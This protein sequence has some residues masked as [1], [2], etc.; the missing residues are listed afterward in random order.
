VKAA[1]FQA[2]GR[3][4]VTDVPTPEPGP[5]QVRIR[6]RRCGVCG[7]DVHIHHGDFIATYPLVGGHELAG[8]IDAVGE[9]VVALRPGD[10]VAPDP[11]I[12]CG[13]CHFCRIGRRNHC[14]AFGALGVTVDGGFAEYTVAPQEI[15]YPIGDLPY[16]AGACAEPLA[17]VL[18][19]VRRAAPQAGSSALIFG[20]GPI[21]LL[22]L[23]ALLRSGATSA[24]SV[25]PDPRRRELALELGA[26]AAVEP[27]TDL[28]G[29]APHGFDLV[30]DATGI[31]EVA[32]DLTRHAT[33]G[34]TVMYFGVCPPDSRISLSPFDVYKRDLTIV[35]S[36]SLATE[37]SAALD[38]LGCPGA[39]RTEPL[40]SDVISLD[41][42]PAL[43][44]DG[45]PP[46]SLKIQVEP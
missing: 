6:V 35:G 4:V 19:G 17:C 32:G 10:R 5:G 11:V 42:L 21:G 14:E 13:R 3:L 36:F 27:G 24:V 1:V 38:M 22:L 7:T 15:V 39:V 45:A 18:H 44:E 28:G 43:L 41:D 23:Q 2:P 33:S 9:G 16:T 26:S 46:S 8:D 20:A 31:P 12:S 30:V 25:E 29:F 34:G 40:V 37:F